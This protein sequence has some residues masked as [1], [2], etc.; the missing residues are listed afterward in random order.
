MRL[1]LKD[2]QI[3]GWA[4]LANAALPEGPWRE[5]WLDLAACRRSDP[6]LFFGVDGVQGSRPSGEARRICARC[7]VLEDCRSFADRRE[8]SLSRWNLAG[9]WA[10]ETPVERATRRAGERDT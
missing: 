8:G 2:P 4:R 6:E 7:P 10:G 5:E 3:L 9:V 1:L